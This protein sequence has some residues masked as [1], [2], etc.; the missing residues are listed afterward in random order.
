[1]DITVQVIKSNLQ[2]RDIQKQIEIRLEELSAAMLRVG[3][4]ARDQMRGNIQNTIYRQPSS[5]NLEKAIELESIS[6][7]SVGVGNLNTLNQQAPYWKIVNYGGWIPAAQ[8]QWTLLGWWGGSQNTSNTL[9]RGSN[10]GSGGSED[11]FL[12][13]GQRPFGNTKGFAMKPRNP[14]S[15]KN[16]IERT[17]HWLTAFWVMHLKQA[18][19]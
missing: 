8:G 14:I 2:A 7:F 16:Y 17:N 11:F 13:Q 9:M 5:G 1:M 18:L 19:K 4:L 15:P 6:E 3:G 12:S 10:P